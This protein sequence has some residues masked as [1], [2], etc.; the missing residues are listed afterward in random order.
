ML[1]R[2]IFFS[3]LSITFLGACDGM[4][5]SLDEYSGEVVYPAKYDTIVGHIGYERVEI[6]L[7]KA[8]RIPSDEI[9]LGKA[10]KTIVEYDDQRIVIDSLVSWVNITGLTQPK[11]YRFRIYTI[12][13]FDNKSVPHEIALIPYTDSDVAG[14]AINSP[15]VLTSPSSAVVDWPSGLSSVL[16]DYRSLSFSYTDKDGVEHT[17]ERGADSRFF[18]PNLQSGEPTTVTITYN[19]VP[20]IN[21]VPIL[22]SIPFTTELIINTPTESTPFTPAEQAVLE[23]NGVTT[24]TANG[25]A[26]IT[27]LVYPIHANSLQDI[28]YF[29]NLKELDLTGGD[30]FEMPTLSYDR[31]DARST[32]G[33]GDWV[34][35]ARKVAD[36]PSANA[37]TLKDMLESGLIEKV[38]YVPH[39]MGLDELLNPYVE[40]GVVELVTTPA[41][42]LIPMNYLVDGVV[43]TTAFRMDITSPATDAPVGTDL[44]N[45]F[46]A[47]LRD[48]NA[49][50]VLALPTEY[51]FNVEEYKYLKFKVY[52][53][54]KSSFEG[55]YDLYQKLWPRFMNHLWSFSQNSTFGREGWDTNKEDFQ[56]DDVD[57]ETWTDVTVDLSEAVGKHNRVVVMNVGGETSNEFNPPADIVYYFANFRFT[58]E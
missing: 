6:D 58:K 23:A 21:N 1:S 31:N 9:N 17:G 28:F 2:I 3:L 42:A 44:Q 18:I 45:V 20:K 4:Y 50:F 35:F 51:R 11:L 12:D 37:Q 38:R 19:V 22:D 43:Q 8:G 53:P 32:V 33:G 36:M 10:K 16:L 46:K 40:S 56:I 39:T 27:K 47:I 34:A 30:L 5:D 54:S 52:A 55:A 14:L 25:V 7:M 24:F 41:E 13:E 26:S 49:S 29:P 57:L 15:R 48:R